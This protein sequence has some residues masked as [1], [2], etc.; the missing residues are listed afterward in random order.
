[1]S[2]VAAQVP[3][4][5]VPEVG[6][7]AL[8]QVLV[9]LLVLGAQVLV[10]VLALVRVLALVL[11]QVRLH[12]LEVVEEEVSQH[13]IHCLQLGFVI[14]IQ[15]SLPKQELVS[16]HLPWMRIVLLPNWLMPSQVQLAR[17]QL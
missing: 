12:C 4:H 3:Q 5:V 7:L 9:D 1:M 14:H 10:W 13:P 15:S 11:V 8:V 2:S 16:V 6:A 17:Q